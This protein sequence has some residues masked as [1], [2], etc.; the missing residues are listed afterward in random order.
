VLSTFGVGKL[1]TRPKFSATA[2]E[3]GNTVDEPT[4]LIRS[5]LCASATPVNA[6]EPATASAA[7]KTSTLFISESP[8]FFVVW[9][10]FI[11]GKVKPH[12]MDASEKTRSTKPDFFILYQAYSCM[13]FLYARPEPNR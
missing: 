12:N 2:V 8:N 5:R 9:Q 13:T 4:M 1:V 7:L 6:K 10:R 11:W 3:N